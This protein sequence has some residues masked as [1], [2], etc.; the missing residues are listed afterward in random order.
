MKLGARML[1]TGIAIILALLIAELLHIPSPAFVGI[2]A[3]FAI[4]PTIYRSYLTI[5]DQVQGNILGAILAIGFV[6]ALGNHVLVIGLAAIVA[7]GLMVKFK[8]E[9][10]IRLALVTIVA[11][12][13]AP[14]DDFLQ[15]A[16]LRSGSIFL[17]ILSAFIVNL[18]F[19]PPKYETKLFEGISGVTEDLVKWM[20]LSTRFASEEG[21]LK[22]DLAQLKERLAGNHQL[23]SMYKEERKY[24]RKSEYSKAR[25]VV[26]YRQMI[27]VN[28]KSLD[29]LRLQHQYENILHQLPEDLQ[30]HSRQRL[31]FLLSYHEQLLMKFMGRVKQEV[32]LDA[33]QDEQIDINQL[34][35]AFIN[36]IKKDDVINGYQPYH[37]IHFFSAML[38]YEEQLEHLEKLIRSFQKYHEKD[39]IFKK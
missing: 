36:E 10:A 13:A 35:D 24:F 31:D 20:R 12:M 3:I 37:L 32:E 19:L 9:N 17:G 23:Y 1:K 11:V 18:V 5:I 14:T 15:V 8:L 34:F 28:Q 33:F 25:K 7:I 2:G 21:F 22:K 38:E 4:Q 29:I 6:L 26:I 30:N 16:L 39:A 27:Q